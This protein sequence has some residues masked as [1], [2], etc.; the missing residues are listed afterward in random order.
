M[1]VFLFRETAIELGHQFIGIVWEGVVN[2][3]IALGVAVV[4]VTAIS[5]G[6]FYLGILYATHRNPKVYANRNALDG[7]KSGGAFAL[8]EVAKGHCVWLSGGKTFNT[9]NQLNRI[10]KIILPDPRSESTKRFQTASEQYTDT[11]F[12]NIILTSTKTALRRNVA[13]GWYPDFV[14]A[15]WWIG[16][17]ETPNAFVHFEV[18]M[19]YSRSRERP[20]FR[21]YRWQDE[22]IYKEY[23]DVFDLMWDAAY[24]PTEKDLNGAR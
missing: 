3:G 21:V 19:P 10:D 23:C 4:L 16:D 18:V 22:G 14:G 6:L 1:A 20:S 8:D 7:S 15:S 2:N 12:T 11:D 5:F 9:G 24:K 17:R 13:I